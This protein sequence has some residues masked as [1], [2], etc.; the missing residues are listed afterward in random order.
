MVLSYVGAGSQ[1]S[2]GPTPGIE[3]WK[4]Y[5]LGRWPGGIDLG[6][7]GIRNIRGGNTLSVHAV[8]RA[9]DWRYANPGPGRK[10]AEEAMAFTIEHHELLGIQAIHD[11]VGCR[12]WRSSRSGSGPAWKQQK[13][14]NGMGEAWASWFHFEVHPDSALHVRP[15]TDVLAG[16]SLRIE[17]V[18]VPGSTASLPLPPL[19]VGAAGARVAQL[20]EILAFWGYYQSRIDGQY[21]PRTVAAVQEWQKALASL[22]VGRA[23]GVYGPRTHAAAAA[24][25]AT[26]ATLRAA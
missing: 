4:A 1:P 12:I 2:S 15:V 21:G 18:V 14:G 11:Y 6:T 13:S 19:R 23:D 5:V 9:W 20:Q 17:P 16:H 24:S 25:Y 7:W 8:G 10:A 22:N 3:K 26:L